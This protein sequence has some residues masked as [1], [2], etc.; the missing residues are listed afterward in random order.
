MLHVNINRIHFWP[1]EGI[2]MMFT[3]GT[4]LLDNEDGGNGQNSRNFSKSLL[5][6]LRLIRYT[7]TFLMRDESDVVSR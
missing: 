5:L 6:L 2:V 4:V 7:H 3:T 1:Y